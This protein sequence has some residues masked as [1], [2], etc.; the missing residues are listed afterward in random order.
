MIEDFLVCGQYIPIPGLMN[1]IVSNV[2]LHYLREF[3]VA[4]IQRLADI[5]IPLNNWVARC[6]IIDNYPM[7]PESSLKILFV[8]GVT[9]KISSLLLSYTQ[10]G[11]NV[12]I[13]CLINA[14]PHSFP[15]PAHCVLK[16]CR[17]HLYTD[18]SQSSIIVQLLQAYEKIEYKI[19]SRD[20]QHASQVLAEWEQR[21]LYPKNMCDWFA[22]LFQ[23]YSSSQSIQPNYG[24]LS[25]NT[26]LHPVTFQWRGGGVS[27]KLAGSFNEWTEYIPL[28]CDSPG[29]SF[30]KVILEL[31]EGIH[32]YKF[33]VDGEWQYDP[34]APLL[35][36]S[37]S[38]YK[39]NYV[40]VKS[41]NN[42]ETLTKK[43]REIWL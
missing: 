40:N 21:N 12:D 37:L 22:N 2:H 18:Q 38:G 6:E 27:I 14:L 25:S 3:D 39:N 29:S 23:V 10:S 13:E 9:T 4:L 36:E 17:S 20:R 16:L 1:S 15:N 30:P 8:A 24:K 5:V 11:Y 35:V 28:I 31:P 19:T 41:D 7:L 32:Q 43:E 26:K 34:D 42:S 33:I